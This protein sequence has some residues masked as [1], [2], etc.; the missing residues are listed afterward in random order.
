MKLII[1][2]CDSCRQVRRVYWKTT[3][4]GWLCNPCST[5]I[6]RLS[7]DRLKTEIVGFIEETRDFIET[8]IEELEA[9]DTEADERHD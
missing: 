5:E 3:N 4:G 9:I 2:R 8:V 1:K 7:L 6:V